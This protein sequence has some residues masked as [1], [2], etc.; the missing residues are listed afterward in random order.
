MLLLPDLPDTSYIKNT[1]TLPVPAAAAGKMVFGDDFCIVCALAARN[2]NWNNGIGNTGSSAGGNQDLGLYTWTSATFAFMTLSANKEACYSG[3]RSTAPVAG[4]VVR[5][6]STI[7]PLPYW[8]QY[9]RLAAPRSATGKSISADWLATVTSGAWAS[10]CLKADWACALYQ[11]PAGHT[12]TTATTA[13]PCGFTPNT[14]STFKKTIGG[15]LYTPVA[16]VADATPATATANA[17]M[18]C[19]SSGCTLTVSNA[20]TVRVDDSVCVVCTVDGVGLYS[21]LTYLALQALGPADVLATA[22]VADVTPSKLIVAGVTDTL[23]L[24][25]VGVAP[26]R[27]SSSGLIKY[28]PFFAAGTALVTDGA[29]ATGTWGRYACTAPCAAPTA[30][31]LTASANTFDSFFWAYDLPAGATALSAAT[32]K[33]IYTTCT[34]KAASAGTLS[35]ATCSSGTAYTDSDTAGGTPYLAI[36]TTTVTSRQVA[37]G[38]TTLACVVCTGINPIT[39]L[40]FTAFTPALPTITITSNVAQYSQRSACSSAIPGSVMAPLLAANAALPTAISPSAQ[41]LINFSAA[42]DSQ[43]AAPTITDASLG[44]PVSPSDATLYFSSA[45]TGTKAL[46]FMPQQSAAAT[47]LGTALWPTTGVP[48]GSY[49]S[50]VLGSCTL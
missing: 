5:V 31:T 47:A 30:T 35:T 49:N 8:Y 22:G 50:C 40:A 27:A 17:I 34:L 48:A 18:T 38:Y 1:I 33:T 11:F 29:D 7:P 15:A 2:G 44:S 14:D 36:S 20:K 41:Y 42:R 3:F 10:T 19:A 13:S 9:E 37:A 45:A 21:S 24:G 43:Q 16:Y 28:G 46:L 23:V 4:T 26:R 32:A 39:S 6:A 12:S 25:A